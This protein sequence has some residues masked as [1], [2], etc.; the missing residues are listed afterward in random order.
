M[1]VKEIF[2]FGFLIAFFVGCAITH[3][4]GPYYGKVVDGETKIPIEGA[5]VLIVYKTQ[6]IGLAG[7]VAQFADAHE[8]VTDKNGEF[9]IPAIRINKF[10]MIS[11]WELHPEVRIFKPGY[12]CYPMH[13]Y[14]RPKVD[15]GSLPENQYVTI[16]LPKLG[17]KEERLE[18]YRCYPSELVPESKYKNL[19]HLIQQERM[20]LGLEP[21]KEP[22]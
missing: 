15:Y 20:V 22:K 5:A 3:K 7:P 6:Q 19:F 16:E 4:Y 13:K 11:G 17:S 9:K 14:A 18:N 2:L 10:R 21:R 8:T 1:R 12:G